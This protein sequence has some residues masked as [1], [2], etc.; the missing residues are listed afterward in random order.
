VRTKE[1]WSDFEFQLEALEPRILLTA[2]GLVPVAAAV[3]PEALAPDLAQQQVV[4][5]SLESAGELTLERETD[6]CADIFEGLDRE[7]ATAGIE[8]EAP[9]TAGPGIAAPAPP[10]E[11]SADE[12]QEAEPP[13]TGE[14]SPEVL[15]PA[16][17]EPLGASEDLEPGASASADSVPSLTSRLVDM[18]LAAN[19]PPSS[20]LVSTFLSISDYPY[21][22]EV[23]DRSTDGSPD[24]ELC[25]WAT[26]EIHLSDLHLDELSEPDISR[27]VV[28]GDDDTD[29]TLIVDVLQD[30]LPSILVFNGGEAG[31]DTLVISGLSDGS[32]TPDADV[33]GSGLI[34]LGDRE[35][36][37]T[38]LE[39]VLIDG[40][41]SGATSFTF[42][43]P[44]AADGLII[45]SPAA[46]QTRIS[47]TSGGTAFESV[48]FH[49]IPTVIIDTGT[50]DADGDDADSIT[51][52][53]DSLLAAGLQNLSIL[54]G[55]GDDVLTVEDDD[56]SLPVLGGVLDWD[57]GE[58]SDTLTGADAENTWS[59]L[60]ENAGDL[61]ADLLFEGVENLVGAAS[62]ADT[63]LI[64]SGGALDGEMDGRGGADS[65]DCSAV[66]AALEFTIEFD[67]SVAV[68]TAPDLWASLGILPAELVTLLGGD[69]SRIGTVRN[70]DSLIGGADDNT[71]VFVDGG[72]FPGTID[73]GSTEGKQTLDYSAYAGGASVDFVAGTATGT[74]GIMNFNR[75]V[76]GEGGVEVVGSGNEETLAFKDLPG[77]IES[78][79]ERVGLDNIEGTQ[80]NDTLI[81]TDGIN[82]IDGKGGDDILEGLGGIDTYIFSDGWGI[83][84][85]EETSS[86]GLN[87]LD[88]TRVTADLTFTI[89]DTGMVSVTD[90][91][92]SLFPTDHIDVLID[93]QG[94]DSFVFEDMAVWEGT[95]GKPNWLSLLL[96]TS[97][98]DYGSNTLDLSAYSTGV[99]VDLGVKVPF[100]EMILF[101]AAYQIETEDRIAPFF[102]NIKNVIGG[103]GDDL[104]WGNSE[105]NALKGG[106]GDDTIFGRD[107]A[108]TFDGGA[109][110]DF[111]YGG[112][113]EESLL[114][115]I[116]VLTAAAAGTGS[117]P[118]VLL[119]DQFMLSAV[120]FAQYLLGGSGRSLQSFVLEKVLARDKNVVTYADAPGPVTVD[121]SLMNTIFVNNGVSTSGDA[122]NDTLFDIHHVIGSEFDDVLTGNI[123]DNTI[124]GGDGDDELYGGWGS[125]T[126]IGG[127]GD[128]WLDGG[129]AGDHLVIGDRDV[130]SYVDA[131]S[132]VRVDLRI[133]GAQDTRQWEILRYGNDDAIDGLVEGYEYEVV[134]VSGDSFKLMSRGGDTIEVILAAPGGAHRL[135]YE[136]GFAAFFPSGPEAIAFDT[137]EITFLGHDFTDDQVVTYHAMGNDSVGGLNDGQSYK[138]VKVGDDHVSLKLLDDTA[139]DLAPTAP[140]GG[141]THGLWDGAV[142]VYSFTPAAMVVNYEDDRITYP[143]HGF[144]GGEIV[145]YDAMGNDSIGGLNDGEDY[146]VQLE[147]P[148]AISLISLDDSPLDLA[149][150]TEGGGGIHSLEEGGLSRTFVPAGG[151]VDYGTEIITIARHGF[152]VGQVVAYGAGGN[153]A[154][155]GLTDG[156]D[157]KVVVLGADTLSLTLL[158]DTPCNLVPT[159]SG[160]GGIH[161]FENGTL[162]TFVPAGGDVDYDADT[163]AI[164]GHGFTT[165]QV[166]TYDAGDNEA[167]GGLEDGQDY[168]VIVVTA[169][170]IQVTAVDSPADL[171][172][173]VPGPAHYFE[174]DGVPRTFI[175]AG[176][177]VDYDAETFTI[178]DHGFSE[179]DIVTYGVGGVLAIADEGDTVTPT[180]GGDKVFTTEG[181]GNDT[182]VNMEGLEGS[183][184]DDIL[185]GNDQHNILRGGAG[186][187][188]LEGG[189]G[190]DFL[191][192]GAGS[193]TT[194]YANMDEGVLINLWLPLPQIYS[195]NVVDTHSLKEIE[196]VIGSDY[197]DRV[198]GNFA[199]NVIDGGY[200]NDILAGLVGADTYKFRDGWGYDTVIDD[201]EA[202]L[203]YLGQPNDWVDQIENALTTAAEWMAK[204]IDAVDV[205]QILDDAAATSAAQMPDVLDFSAVAADLSVRIQ[206]FGD[207][208]TGYGANTTYEVAEME[209]VIGGGG[210]DTFIIDDGET[211]AGTLDGGLPDFDRYPEADQDV[212]TLDLSAYTESIVVDL[213]AE[214]GSPAQVNDGD[215][216]SNILEGVSNIQNV[217]GG[218]AD[219]SI[220]G[221]G[222]NNL[223]L[224]GP[225]ND[226]LEGRDGDDV[227]EGGDG[228]DS[229]LGGEGFDLVSYVGYEN[230][231]DTT[232]VTVDLSL[233]DGE[234]D[235]VGAGID[236]LKSIEGAV[237]TDYDDTLIGDEQDNLLVGGAGEDL[238]YG[239]AGADFISGDAGNDQLFGG[240]GDDTMEGGLG[241]DFLQGG[242]GEDTVSYMYPGLAVTVDLSDPEKQDTLGAG[243]DTLRSFE[244]LIG[245]GEADILLG[246]DEPN[247]I[248]GGGGD[249]TLRGR[250][251]GDVL[252]G[253]DGDDF[254]YGGPGGDALS[255]GRGDDLLDG[256]TDVGDPADD[257]GFDIVSYVDAEGGVRIDLNL[258]GVEQDTVSLGLDTLQNVEGVMGSEYG[259]IL[260]GDEEDNALLGQGGDDSLEG[261]QG[262]DTLYGGEGFDFVSYALAAGSVFV[263]LGLSWSQET[264]DWTGWDEIAGVEGVIGSAFND[265]LTGNEEDN[266]LVGGEGEDELD[267]S[268]G[269]NTASYEYAFEGVTAN[270]ANPTPNDGEASGDTY[271][272][273]HNL[274]GSDFDDVLTGDEEDNVISGGDGADEIRGGAGDDLLRGEDGD[275]ELYGEE[276]DDV[277]VGGAGE[278]KFYGGGTG[279]NTASYR[280]AADENEDDDTT[281]I[282]INMNDDN[283]NTG[284]AEGD[285]FED[286]HNIEGSAG[287]DTLIANDDGVILYGLGGDDWLIG[288]AGADELFGGSGDDVLEGGDGD[289]LLDGGEGADALF[290]YL[291]EGDSDDD[292]GTDTAS[293]ADAESGVTVDLDAGTGTNDEAEGDELE[294]I[295]NLVGSDHN[296]ELS[297]DDEDNQLEGGEGDDILTGRE[298]DDVLDGGEGGDF[299][300]YAAA[301]RGVVVDLGETAGQHVND[302]EGTDTLIDIENVAG[303][304]RDDTLTGDDSDNVLVG[305]AGRDTLSGLGGDD[306]LLGQDDEDVLDGGEGNDILDGGAGG[307]TLIGGEDPDGEDA[308]TA[309]YADA[310]NAVTVSLLTG[311]GIGSEAEGDVLSEIENLVGSEYADELTGDDFINILNGGPGDDTLIGGGGD[312]FLEGGEGDDLIQGGAHDDEG[313]T[314]SYKED[315][316]AVDV[317]LG[318]QATDGSGGSDTLEGI[319]NVYGSAHD[320]TLTGDAGANILW[321]NE[322]ADTLSGGEGDDVLNGGSGDDTLAGGAGDDTYMFEDS[323]DTDVIN[324]TRETSGPTE[325]AL[326]FSLAL[327]D[328]M[329]TIH[330]GGTIS[331]YDTA[332]IV[333]HAS[334]ITRL[335]GGKGSDEFFIERNAIHQP[336]VDGGPGGSD[337]LDYSDFLP[338][339]TVTLALAG[340][341]VVGEQ[342]KVTLDEETEHVYEVEGGET[343]LDVA[344]ALAKAINDDAAE[345]FV[346]AVQ[347]DTDTLVI[348][349]LDGDDF[350]VDAT[351]E[352]TG[353]ASGFF[354]LDDTTSETTQ[355]VGLSGPVVIG[356]Q[357][358]VT[359]NGTTNHVFNVVDIERREETLA[360]VAEGLAESINTLASSE[361]VA[362]AHGDTLV[363]TH[364]NGAAFT[365]DFT[366]PAGDS[367]LID[368]TIDLNID[369][370][371]ADPLPFGT[372][373]ASGIESLIGGWGDD[374]LKVGDEDGIIN[375]GPG[376]DHLIG[377]EGF[378]LLL[379]GEGVDTLEGGGGDDILD[380]GPEGDFL[381]GHYNTPAEDTGSDTASYYTYQI[382][383]DGEGL[384]ANLTT[385]A[386]ST[387]DAF[388]DTF[389]GI[390]NLMGSIGA[391]ALV[392]TPEANTIAGMDGNDTLIGLGGHDRFDG[393]IGW[394]MVSYKDYAAATGGVYVDLA[395]FD[396]VHAHEVG[397]LET[398]ADVVQALADDINANAGA[399]YLATVDGGDTLV[400]TN[401]VE[402]RFVVV[403]V[404]PESGELSE[405]GTFAHTISLTFTGEAEEGE[406]WQ[407]SI[408]DGA[409]AVARDGADTI[410]S[411]DSLAF[412][413][414]VTGSPGDDI[415][416]GDL[417]SNILIGGPGVDIIHGMDGNDTLSGGPGDDFLYGGADSD[418]LEGGEGADVLNGYLEGVDPTG[419]KGL[420]TASYENSDEAVTVS[421]VTGSGA[422]GHAEGDTLSSIENLTGSGH[423]DTLT[424]D[425][426]DNVIIGNA[427]EDVLSGGGDVE[428]DMVSYETSPGPGGVT[429]ALAGATDDG[430]GFVDHLSGFEA[431]RGSDYDDH[432][433]GDTGD[434][435]LEG[436]LGNDTLDGGGG[437]DTLEGDWGD[438]ILLDSGGDDIHDG[439][440]GSDTVSYEG[441]SADLTVDLTILVAQD[442]GTGE[443]LVKSIEHLTGGDGNDVLR[444]DSGDNTLIGGPGIDTLV[445]GLGEDTLIGGEDG[446]L[447]YG[448]FIDNNDKAA[449]TDVDTASYEGSPGWVEV[450]LNVSPQAGGAIDGH[451]IGDELYDIEGIIGSSHNDILKGD[452][453]DNVLKGGDGEDYLYG[454]EGDDILVGGDG[455]DHLFGGDD[456]DTASYEGSTAVEL[457]L[458]NG[459]YTGGHAD[460]DDLTDIENLTGSDYADIL[461]GDKN[462]NVL[463]GGDGNDRFHVGV[464]FGDLGPGET[465]GE[466]EYDGEEGEDIFPDFKT[467]TNDAGGVYPGGFTLRNREPITVTVGQHSLTA[468]GLIMFSSESAITV[469]DGVELHSTG[470]D[471]VLRVISYVEPNL[472]N[473]LQNF[474]TRNISTAEITVGDNVTLESDAGDVYISTSTTTT[475][476]VGYEYYRIG[477]AEG[478]DAM[479]VATSTGTVSFVKQALGPAD[480][481][482][483][484]KPTYTHAKITTTDPTINFVEDGFRPGQTIIVDGSKYN[485]DLYK[486][487]SVTPTELQ[488]TS[489]TLKATETVTETTELGDEVETEHN[490]TYAFGWPKPGTVPEYLPAASILPEKGAKYVTIQEV[491]TTRLS[492]NPI[493]TIANF[494][495]EAQLLSSNEDNLVMFASYASE[496]IQKLLT[497]I[498]HESPIV[499]QFLRKLPFSDKLNPSAG[500]PVQVLQSEANSRIAIPGNNVTIRAGGNVTIESTASSSATLKSTPTIGGIPVS[501]GMTAVYSEAEALADVTG[502]GTLLEAVGDVNLTATASNSLIETV[503]VTSKKL[504][505]VSPYKTFLDKF[506]LQLAVGVAVAD[507]TTSATVGDGVTIIATN[508]NVGAGNS[509]RFDLRV[510]AASPGDAA[511]APGKLTNTAKTKDFEFSSKQGEEIK[512]TLTPI[513]NTAAILGTKERTGHSTAMKPQFRIRLIGPDG[514]FVSVT[515]LEKEAA[516]QV[517]VYK[518]PKD[519]K[520][521][522]RIE[523][524][525]ETAFFN[526]DE[527]KVRAAK[528]NI[529]IPAMTNSQTPGDLAYDDQESFGVAT[530]VGVS[531]VSSTSTARIDGTVRLT[532]GSLGVAARSTTGVSTSDL[533]YDPGTGIPGKTN[534]NFLSVT[535]VL[536]SSKAPLKKKDVSSDTATKGWRSFANVGSKPKSMVSPTDKKEPSTKGPNLTG[537]VA[538]GISDNQARAIIGDGADIEVN[539]GDMTVEAFV[540][541]NVKVSV[542]AHVKK[543]SESVSGAGAVF[544]GRYS[545]RAD[546][547]IGDGAV[548]DVTG[549]LAVTANTKYPNQILL[550]DD[551]DSFKKDVNGFID[552]Q[553]W[554]APLSKMGL[555]PPPVRPAGP[556]PPILPGVGNEVIWKIKNR[557]VSLVKRQA[558][559]LNHRVKQGAK[560]S[561]EQLRRG[562]ETKEKQLTKVLNFIPTILETPNIIEKLSTTFVT[563]SA[564]AGKDTDYREAQAKA[565]AEK[566]E[567][568]TGK[569]DRDW[570]FAFSGSINVLLVNNEANAWIGENARVTGKDVSVTADSWLETI[571]VTGLP[572][573]NITQLLLGRNKIAPPLDKVPNV[574]EKTKAEQ[575]ELSP[576]ELKTY[577]KSRMRQN[578]GEFLNKNVPLLS[579]GFNKGYDLKTLKSRL[580]GRQATS[581]LFQRVE[582]QLLF[583]TKSG[584][585]GLG[586]NFQH[587][588]YTNIARATIREGAVVSSER[589]VRVEA[590]THNLLLDLTAA[591]AAAEGLLA[592]SGAGTSTNVHNTSIATV[593][594]GAVVYAKCNVIVNADTDNVLAT[595]TGT[596]VSGSDLGIGVSVTINTVENNVLALVGDGEEAPLAV[597]IPT[598]SLTYTDGPPRL[599]RLDGGHWLDDGFEAGNWI[600]VTGLLN[601]AD[602]GLFKILVAAPAVLDLEEG[603]K[604]SGAATAGE[605]T[606]QKM[607]SLQADG[608][609]LS[610]A[611]EDPTNVLCDS[612]TGEGAAAD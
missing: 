216:L 554:I 596:T 544:V 414:D 328:I 510:S 326:D 603:S 223:L 238:I 234:Q 27:Y 435:V 190:V 186:N 244:N 87:I 576:E 143:S 88:F 352:F 497:S 349:H 385:P 64:Y 499:R 387:E 392:G 490:L 487:R 530:A 153:E 273:I 528:F 212:N 480:A 8:Q 121:L 521:K 391:D 197:V 236:V 231:V 227:L 411:S 251:D 319:E 350:T 458:F 137:D 132:G 406:R 14:M 407:V 136:G 523:L 167:V 115:I 111:I 196:N 232:G 402:E 437:N 16:T 452:S 161:S 493:K 298:G 222:E 541:E 126:L 45:D 357:W 10:A 51:I 1:R 38:G 426:H 568:S 460:G 512:V 160:G 412:I 287:D 517:A 103:S 570:A 308:D 421:L 172:V 181:A 280:D 561:W 502:Q 306:I 525:N 323:W 567:E 501:V 584:G 361:F 399:A 441:V 159:A 290:G 531:V 171:V 583:P 529:A 300:S 293:Y 548:V 325:N 316:A 77:V 56:L 122:G 337:V 433:T 474:Y 226:L 261:G 169:G 398:L 360:D 138:I 179:G 539:G 612:D 239:M 130:A 338:E 11:Q 154:I 479:N 473:G 558:T 430:F 265:A 591:G 49:D 131:G 464:A 47:G 483:K 110:D 550:D 79:M 284:E 307:D 209:M 557:N 174:M 492:F 211:F 20:E 247:T 13:S 120:E 405:D 354:T 156:Q 455:P 496:Q 423:G 395:L 532:D 175:P 304:A 91:T 255:G 214:N 282:V 252:L 365:V 598:G 44:G 394:D 513:A 2:D 245:S 416:I 397:A 253:E 39:P 46:G 578:V 506:K 50:N 271:V 224:G 344:L 422:G 109:G 9:A 133:D 605:V 170:I 142:L 62:A 404:G 312:D 22:F 168:K 177:D 85:I 417:L 210:C 447:L 90:G 123:L 533:P 89:H 107:R 176:G 127:D 264:G 283:E 41:A 478:L 331:A 63:F 477:L 139:C 204:F 60:D 124:W 292:L 346:A 40:A 207:V 415:L 117:T 180:G 522:V 581:D 205:L 28:N 152:T 551:W 321:G 520:Y 194:S 420:D 259:D 7:D 324:E 585:S 105:S 609:T 267:G 272:E 278:D 165:D 147:G 281:G 311:I 366:N 526:G 249:D 491:E 571:N 134:E 498:F 72:N 187:D 173:A 481:K 341:I 78:L 303:S 233:L 162:E 116:A 332:S 434:N 566:Q 66:D 151:D 140:G 356:E 94:D 192:G 25:I 393:G 215:E 465:V 538:I 408:L 4:S 258:S 342:W 228:D 262:D 3:N 57:G 193:D 112:F 98:I 240:A 436:G 540:E 590:I 188:L 519:G 248:T 26:G 471:V 42:T 595:Y 489:L 505:D 144:T 384:T 466:D 560:N 358:Q 296:D 317:E 52:R 488:I 599:E 518:A 381:Y 602:D 444:G 573:I 53:N 454:L 606:I 475:R 450:D 377:G 439:G 610:L 166:V 221:S 442:T 431:L 527:G 428:G 67:G 191:T 403:P 508:A 36:H 59:L 92:N 389:D 379:G 509:N 371:V 440:F 250:G 569:S 370:S 299:V 409:N 580:L 355:L 563:S 195:T 257:D 113:D 438:D 482:T 61:N 125:D 372:S 546:A 322:G 158:N 95:I 269:T 413:E 241:D 149:A 607:G 553:A 456:S 294:G 266:V 348:T 100:L 451:H 104:I 24:G 429:V 32:Y 572:S 418:L 108:D 374:V 462:N 586:I 23:V 189:R 368:D 135:G 410:I 564:Q 102:H 359:L 55:A 582:G 33:F 235:T 201:L 504:I 594:D 427:G 382:D 347:E 457:D 184:Y 178:A 19:P 463:N 345:E 217:I 12:S 157:Y 291:E 118:E 81:G 148:D 220:L 128:D 84:T 106:D 547:W 386:E 54:T 419:T 75:V 425:E 380:G 369:L 320:D 268:A 470:G 279:T 34:T 93:G 574:A 5:A 295:E 183:G 364:L 270:L 565:D 35:V 383:V 334:H 424:G 164:A 243:E 69:G 17:T 146:R 260:I 18:E 351:V 256:Y 449:D 237:G 542:T 286:I 74:A 604:I 288:G 514:K 543:A 285:T 315:E 335:V 367:F 289:D 601:S 202:L 145:T 587:T 545:N 503:T 313:D 114:E 373:G 310:Q 446:D 443:D 305:G 86:G 185:I 58:G 445:G 96:G 208:Q 230:I 608:A 511:G 562:L 339:A 469:E 390:E 48:T 330:A 200:G 119:F 65:L 588:G 318:V 579:Y 182:L 343:F 600:R 15:A 555:A 340:A 378:N 68:Q 301:L 524:V 500:P 353:P 82:I 375:G 468:S 329:F 203:S 376:I 515:S 559:I 534:K 275:D 21:P 31:F 302:D 129:D 277:L 459:S 76:A 218:D 536:D 494:G 556:L 401:L 314:A 396:S 246:N 97:L 388:G 71:F 99:Y 461:K 199:D 453:N 592:L 507:T 37:F 263:D 476:Q 229:L 486:I 593:A 362:V 213:E 43:T 575:N 6:N 552:K 549:A 141:G 83:D 219:D 611:L 327:A 336:S 198:A 70:V 274:I 29:D 242:A 363:V 155:G 472:L 516:K 333:E 400:V 432:L 537:A 206:G 577:R 589:N 101:Q 448:H 254:L 535:A 30:E 163:F 484:K 150:T 467:L 73:G 495:E 297:G 276:G 597:N 225:G 80:G 309:T 485:N